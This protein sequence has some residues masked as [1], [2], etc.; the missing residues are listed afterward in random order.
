MLYSVNVCP[1]L[2]V[3]GGVPN[4][5]LAYFSTTVSVLCDVG[6]KMADGVSPSDMIS[7]C[8][9]NSSWSNDIPDCDCKFMYY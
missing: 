9:A 3:L 2:D 5:T 6:F 4:T 1:E 7:T 8:L